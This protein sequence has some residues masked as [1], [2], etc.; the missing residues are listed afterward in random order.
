MYAFNTIGQ[1]RD[2]FS[3][4]ASINFYLKKTGNT[5]YKWNV[6]YLENKWYKSKLL[7]NGMSNKPQLINF[8]PK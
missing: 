5:A 2:V 6:V 8:N 7:T 4:G 1:D 3:T